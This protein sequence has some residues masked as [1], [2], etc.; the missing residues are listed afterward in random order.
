VRQEVL[1]RWKIPMN[2]SVIEPATF[3][4]E[5]QCLNQMRHRVPTHNICIFWPAFII[6]SVR[7]KTIS[8]QL[9][10]VW[11]FKAHWSRDAP[12]GLT[13]TTVRSAR[14]DLRPKP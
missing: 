5:A 8:I 6:Q 4:L 9:N 10:V 11:P 12:T 2:P 1:S 3:R 13:S 7:Y 14:F